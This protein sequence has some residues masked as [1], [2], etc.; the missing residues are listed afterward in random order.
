LCSRGDSAGK[1]FGPKAK[2]AVAVKGEEERRLGI[3]NFLSRSKSAFKQIPPPLPL[4]TA[5]R[6]TSR[7]GEHLSLAIDDIDSRFLRRWSWVY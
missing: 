6:V 4:H 5:L 3:L 2:V 7:H 1:D